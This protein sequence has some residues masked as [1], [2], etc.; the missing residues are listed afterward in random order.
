MFGMD[1]SVSK[2]RMGTF[3]F[4]LDFDRG[5]FL[6][7]FV[8]RL[9]VKVSLLN[10]LMGAIRLRLLYFGDQLVGK[11]EVVQF[12]LAFLADRIPFLDDFGYNF[13]LSHFGILM[14]VL[15]VLLPGELSVYLIDSI[16]FMFNFILF[17]HSD[18]RAGIKSPN[19]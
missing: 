6:C 19:L 3:F 15:V 16:G 2:T 11:I 12:F 10:A 4:E 13:R 18:Y 1:V 7:S 5:R 17:T 14:F 9:L 8:Q